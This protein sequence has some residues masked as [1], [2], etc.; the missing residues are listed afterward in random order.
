MAGNRQI[1]YSFLKRSADRMKVPTFHSAKVTGP[2]SS[3]EILGL[4]EIEVAYDP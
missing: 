1:S 2:L 3:P 4:F